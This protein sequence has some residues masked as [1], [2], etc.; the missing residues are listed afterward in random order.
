[1]VK[2]DLSKLG[3][4]QRDIALLASLLGGAEGDTRLV[5]GCVRDGLLGLAVNDIDLATRLL[6]EDV[7]ARLKAATIKVIPTGLA[8]GTVT[9][10]T[11]GHPVEITTLRRDV[12][13]DGRHARIAY[14][15]N[16]QEDAARRDFTINALS[17]DMISGEVYDYFVGLDDLEIRAVRFIGDANQRI[18]ED[19][20]RI[21][22]FF[23]FH[24]R[25]GSEAIDEASLQACATHANSLMALSRERIA[26]ELFKLL[27]LPNPAPTIQLMLDHGIFLPVLPE[28]GT[29]AAI[30][31]AR[32]VEREEAQGMPGDPTRRL[33]AL[34][35]PNP[36]MVFDIANRLKCSNHRRKRLSLA[37]GREQGDSD[38]PQT[39]A[40]WLGRES[41]IDRL[42]L[43]EGDSSGLLNWTKPAFK[44]S[45]KDVI[46]SGIA[47]GPS[48]AIVLKAIETRWV[49]SGFPEMGQVQQILAEEVKVEQAKE[50]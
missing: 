18:K 41:A 30:A 13:T 3:Y 33:A 50:R 48:V 29:E 6:P 15:D 8:H 49:S 39:L 20:L 16:W 23:R 7:I 34:L 45:G 10:V 43:G 5:G 22:R 37:A 1:M 27:A 38:N 47:P 14:T 28:I 44:L 19:H 21:L 11:H 40:Y 4:R 46:S 12:S 17:A 32:L 25:F 9:A 42:L 24:A 35:P 36:D 31:L 2:L 26:D